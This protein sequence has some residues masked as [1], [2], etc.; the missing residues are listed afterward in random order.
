V[1]EQLLAH[2]GVREEVELGS[3]FGV[4]AF[5]GGSL[6]RMTDVIADEVV[7][8]SGA[9]R[10][11]VRQPDSLRWHVPSKLFD[12]AASARLA[13]FL[14]HVDVVI[15]IHG[16]GRE[17]SFRRILLGGGHRD[18]AAGLAEAMRPSLAHYEVVDDLGAIPV[19]LRGLHPDNPVNRAR[20]GGVQIELPPRA[21]GLGPF[22]TDRPDGTEGSWLSPH[23]RALIDV[24]ASVAAQGASRWSDQPPSPPAS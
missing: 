22:W 2:P 4:M 20:G 8:R 5:H 14:D 21:R 3:T 19:E 9:S 16:Y 24:L 10:Y 18:L 7:A 15:A 12:P 1:I 17:G 6:E 11:V 13:A 23:T